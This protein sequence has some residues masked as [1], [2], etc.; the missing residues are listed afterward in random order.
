MPKRQKEHQLKLLII[1][2][3]VGDF[4]SMSKASSVGG[5]GE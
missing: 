4:V 2:R 3:R 1:I 5:I